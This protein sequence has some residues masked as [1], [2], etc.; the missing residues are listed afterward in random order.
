MVRE[1]QPNFYLFQSKISLYECCARKKRKIK[2]D[3]LNKMKCLNIKPIQREYSGEIFH[4]NQKI[5]C[6]NNKKIKFRFEGDFD[7]NDSGQKYLELGKKYI[8]K[9]FDDTFYNRGNVTIY[10]DGSTGSTDWFYPDRFLSLKE[11]RKVK[12]KRINEKA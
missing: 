3:K 9:N 10:I 2:K 11:Y 12:L 7:W 5:I 8:V 4:P 1:I 6:I